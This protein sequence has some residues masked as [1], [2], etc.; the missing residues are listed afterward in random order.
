MSKQ[1]GVDGG[2]EGPEAVVRVSDWSSF[3][4]QKVEIIYHVGRLYAKA[5]NGVCYFIT[6]TRKGFGFN[7]P[8]CK[9]EHYCTGIGPHEC[10]QY[11]KNVWVRGEWAAFPV[12]ESKN[13]AAGKPK[14]KK[15]RQK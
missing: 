7:C 1:I 14:G 2:C 3:H 10:P 4:G 8:H 15:D 9:T 11:K 12:I 13:P 5:D 6:D